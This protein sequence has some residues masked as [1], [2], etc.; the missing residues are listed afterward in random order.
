[1]KEKEDLYAEKIDID[2]E[3]PLNINDL[4]EPLVEENNPKNSKKKISIHQSVNLSNSNNYEPPIQTNKF[5]H[6]SINAN[7]LNNN[8]NNPIN[9]IRKEI[10]E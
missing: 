2:S 8:S 1:M 9:R 7:N 3:K 6:N 5:L 10:N 4:T